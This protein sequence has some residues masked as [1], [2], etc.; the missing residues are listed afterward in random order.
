M[1]IIKFS[2]SSHRY[3]TN[4]IGLKTENYKLKKKVNE[5]TIGLN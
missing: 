4:A 3:A 5:V 1:M 2:S